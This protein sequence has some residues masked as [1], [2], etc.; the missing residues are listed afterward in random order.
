[1]GEQSKRID[2]T[3]QKYGRLTAMKCLGE[4]KGQ[5]M[6]QFSC[7]CGNLKTTGGSNVRRGLTLSCGCLQKEAAR[8]SKSTHGQSK[9]PEYRIWGHM[10]GRCHNPKDAAYPDYGGRGITVC[11][12]WRAS[13]VEFFADMGARPSPRHTIER[14]DNNDGYNPKNCAWILR[15]E[16]SQNRRGVRRYLFRGS[17]L[18]IRQLSEQYGIP[19]PSLTRRIEAGWPVARAVLEPLAAKGKR[20]DP[21]WQGEAA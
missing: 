10:I 3:G 21:N 16:Q 9:R 15:E 18:T 19:V 2:M 4:I 12:A 13:Y 20:A 7:D 5:T 6:W 1:M 11:D 14:L 8:S 17:Y